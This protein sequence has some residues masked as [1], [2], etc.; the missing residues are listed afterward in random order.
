MLLTH[1][2]DIAPALRQTLAHRPN[3]LH[4]LLRILAGIGGSLLLYVAFF[5]YEDE[6]A[7]IQKRLEQIWRRPVELCEQQ[8]ELAVKQGKAVLSHPRSAACV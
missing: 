7:R 2:I 5:L 4:I 8:I 3:V 6:E 1:W